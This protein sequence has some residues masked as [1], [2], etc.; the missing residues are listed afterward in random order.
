MFVLLTHIAVI[1]CS[2]Y[3]LLVNKAAQLDVLTD[4]EQRDR[5]Q[6]HIHDLA[7]RWKK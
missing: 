1:V 7:D 5:R 3:A 6:V 2:V 4:G